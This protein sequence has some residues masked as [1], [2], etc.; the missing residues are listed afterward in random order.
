MIVHTPRRPPAPW[1]LQMAGCLGNMP[2]EFYA[3]DN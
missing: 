1:A 2:P 3:N